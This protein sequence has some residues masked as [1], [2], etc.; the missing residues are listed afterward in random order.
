LHLIPG[1]F[2]LRPQVDFAAAAAVYMSVVNPAAAYGAVNV[3]FAQLI[4]PND[5]FTKTGSGQTT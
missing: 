3:S 4:H 1:T 5:N 2:S